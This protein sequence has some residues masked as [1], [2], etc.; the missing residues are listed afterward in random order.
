MKTVLKVNTTSSVPR[1]IVGLI[2]F[3]LFIHRKGVR[4]CMDCFR[5]EST[6]LQFKTAAAPVLS[7][8]S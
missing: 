5:N 2:G 7:E 1:A 4:V 3:Q 8:S 6:L